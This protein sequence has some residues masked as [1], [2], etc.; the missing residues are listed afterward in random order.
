MLNDDLLKGAENLLVGCGEMQRDQRLLVLYEN[1][2]LK[3]YDRAIVDA[4]QA[5]A[6]ALGIDVVVEEVPFSPT[7]ADPSPALEARMKAADRVLFLARAGDQIRFR[8][9]MGDIR[10]MVSYAL[11]GDM[12]ASSFGRTDYKAFVALK[13]AVNASLAHAN[14]VRVTC[15]LGTDFSGPSAAY[16]KDDADVTVARFPMSVFT[17]VP[18]GNFA[19]MIAQ[20]G[21]LTGTGSQYFKPYACH[22]EGVLE[23]HFDGHTITGFDGLKQDIQAAQ[24]FYNFVSDLFDIDPY[25]VHSWHAGI[26][27]GCDYKQPAGQN[28]ERWSGG[29]F[30]NPRLLHFHT[31]GAYPPGEISLNIMDTTVSVDGINL[32]EAGVFH[33]KRIAG[34]DAI[35]AQYSDLQAVFDNPSQNCG[36]NAD[37]HLS[38]D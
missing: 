34:G 3:F 11:D 6:R 1:E 23:V 7:V 26:H 15:P 27:P 5:G 29:A 18:A 2:N 22:L 20:Q 37:G 4:V 10:P 14:S 33:P 35:F 19:G 24:N 13:N 32:W 8:P 30:G 17:P 16:P 21:F 25:F 28:F 9:S 12:L 38:F 31:C 36:Q